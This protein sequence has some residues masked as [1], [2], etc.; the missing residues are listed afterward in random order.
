M[1]INKRSGIWFYGLSGSGKTYASNIF[2][3]QFQNPFIIDGDI[4]RKFISYDIGYS[5]K[6]REIQIS[7]ILG[8]I[9]L[10]LIN[11]HF[12]IA[13][14]VYMTEEIYKECKK[15]NIDVV[16]ILRPFDQIKKIRKLYKNN[17]NVVGNDISQSHIETDKI[18]N[19]GNKEFRNL[20]ENLAR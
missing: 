9:K 12:P 5:I 17:D 19:D 1:K 18:F 13:S 16:E 11:N 20:I 14:T 2:K 3:N 10:A 7:R 6:D 8:I 15:I 4:V